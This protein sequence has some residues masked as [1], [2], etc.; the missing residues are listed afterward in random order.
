M[1]RIAFIFI[2]ALLLLAANA[3]AVESQVGEKYEG[4]TF[5]PVYDIIDKGFVEKTKKVLDE[6]LEPFWEATIISHLSIGNNIA[7]AYRAVVFKHTREYREYYKNER[8]KGGEPKPSRWDAIRVIG[9]NTNTLLD[10]REIRSGRL[11]PEGHAGYDY[12]G[13]INEYPLFKAN[14]IDL[15]IK[16]L[17]T[18]TGYG[19]PSS[20]MGRRNCYP[21]NE[22]MI[23]SIY[24]GKNFE[25]LLSVELML[26]NYVYPEPECVLKDYFYSAYKEPPKNKAIPYLPCPDGR[27]RKRFGKIFIK[28]FNRND[29]LDVL[30][31]Y[32]Q[33]QSRK[34]TEGSKGFDLE[35][36]W[37]A[38]YEETIN[39]GKIEF[40]E[41]SIGN[42]L[43]Q[44][45]LKDFKLTWA[46]GF[47]DTNMCS[48]S[49][50]SLPMIVDIDDPVL[51]E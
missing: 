35:K 2:F 48:S 27:G 8:K 33:Y 44:Q 16:D 36:Q 3:Y 51:K 9:P 17:F 46:K 41:R 12:Y 20:Q 19:I 32:R 30:A 11:F 1:Y 37:F 31:W 38:W 43:A 24:S 21:V 13:C 40:V 45:W 7:F 42:T 18:I 6:T 34:L 10:K 50:K 29:K 5:K 47:P 49:K 25:K 26:L 4:Y 14:T 22:N 15:E 39:G 23:L 28:D